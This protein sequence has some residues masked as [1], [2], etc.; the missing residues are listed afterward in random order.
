MQSFYYEFAVRHGA[1]HCPA[2]IPCWVEVQ[3]YTLGAWGGNSGAR[4]GTDKL[5]FTGFKKAKGAHRSSA[6]R[7]RNYFKPALLGGLCNKG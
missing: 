5:D 6:P 2:R 7:A 1:W 3:I 4:K